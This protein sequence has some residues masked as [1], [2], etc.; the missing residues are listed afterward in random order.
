MTEVTGMPKRSNMPSYPIIGSTPSVGQEVILLA[1]GPL[2][3]TDRPLPWPFKREEHSV[4]AWW[5][6]FPADSFHG[7]DHQHLLT[8][9]RQIRVIHGDDDLRAALRG[10]TDAAIGAALATMPISEI[11]LQIDIAASTLLS[12]ALNCNAAACLV[13][14]QVIGLTDLAHPFAIELAGSWLC[15]GMRHSTAPDQFSEAAAILWQT[16]RERQAVREKAGAPFNEAVPPMV[17]PVK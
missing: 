5:R 4:L 3:P 14:A 6:T 16:F 15:F 10:E 7:A 2:L 11:T 1:D 13:L 17:E 9:L 12:S 8:T